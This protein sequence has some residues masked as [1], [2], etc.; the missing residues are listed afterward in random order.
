[1]DPR[2]TSH[3]PAEPGQRQH[4]DGYLPA[5]TKAIVWIG[6]TLVSWLLAISIVVGVVTMFR[7][8]V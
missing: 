6:V 8:V 3:S 4:P 1:M 5:A 7:W 2:D